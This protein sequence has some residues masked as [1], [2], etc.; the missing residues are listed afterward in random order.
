MDRFEQLFLAAISQGKEVGDWAASAWKT[1]APQG[2]R[3]LKDSRV[4]ETA[5]EN[6]GE[7]RALVR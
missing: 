3:L 6:R 2:Y 5:E 7:L 4:L 1:L